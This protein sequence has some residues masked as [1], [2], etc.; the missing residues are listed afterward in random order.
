M[1][2]WVHD[3]P[4]REAMGPP[5][6]GWTVEDYPDPGSAAWAQ[7]HD[8]VEVVI[9][10]GHDGLEL[11]ALPA[12]RLVQTR[13]AGVDWI[14]GRIPDGV[15]LCDAAGARDGAMA[16]WVVAAILADYKRARTC[17]EL[18][19]ERSWEHIDDLLDVAG[20]RVLIL[21]FGAIGRA[22]EERLKPFGT[23][24]V[25]V[26][27][28][29][30]EGVHAVAALSTLLPDADVIVNLLPLTDETRG[31]IGAEMLSLMRDGALLVNAGR[32]ATVDTASLVDRASRRPDPRRAGRRRPRAPASRASSLDAVERDHQPPQCGRHDR[33]RA[34]VVAAGRR[35]AAPLRDRRA[36]A[37]RRTAT[38]TDRA[39]LSE[40]PREPEP[41]RCRVIGGRRTVTGV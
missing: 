39:E 26:A 40:C 17:A 36:A 14:I 6:D 13:S 32:G 12:L 37:Q 34:R 5:P 9:P 16:E 8:R 22:V 38:A 27:R 3:A 10:G 35:A 20:A 23:S 18:A 29:A 25:R 1:I 2:C 41:G 4:G 30:R 31:L 11:D 28:S 21:G 7:A 15:T 33:R 24:F 19:A